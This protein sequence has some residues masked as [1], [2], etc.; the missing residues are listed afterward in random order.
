MLFQLLKSEEEIERELAEAEEQIERATG[1]RPKGFRGPGFSFSEATLRVLARRGYE[2][3]ASTFPT[4][5]GPLARAYYLM[6]AK[7]SAA[8]R[9]RRKELFGRLSDGRRPLKPYCWQVDGQTLIEIPVTTMPVFKVPMHI[10]YILYLSGYSKALAL[11][12]FQTASRLCRM[13]GT[14]LSL[15][16][17]PLDFL[18]ADDVPDL[19]F[20][21]AMH[22]P[23]ARKLAIVSEALNM[24]TR[25]F[26]ILPLQQHA[27]LVAQTPQLSIVEASSLSVGKAPHLEM[28]S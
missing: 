22:L 15:L 17:H 1:Q 24:M 10:S 5:L 21:P 20:F 28:E 11:K 2:Y 26:D 8:E 12:Y 3:D 23:S 7:L 27:R 16:L 25:H 6:T 19:S 14:Q 13:T 4:Y 18:G 9:E